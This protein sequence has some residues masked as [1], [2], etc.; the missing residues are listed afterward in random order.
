MFLIKIVGN[1]SDQQLGFRREL[2]WL[3]QL[4]LFTVVTALSV[5]VFM[6]LNLLRTDR[7]HSP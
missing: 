2:V 7:R 4:D 5:I 6:S 1:H 3:V